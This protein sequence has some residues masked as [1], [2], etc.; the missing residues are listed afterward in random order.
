MED[1]IN[2]FTSLEIFEGR[3]GADLDKYVLKANHNLISFFYNKTDRRYETNI[4]YDES[5]P[6]IFY[7]PIKFVN[8]M[9][10][11]TKSYPGAFGYK[12][13]LFVN[14]YM[15]KYPLNWFLNR[16]GYFTT[17]RMLE[18][19]GFQY[20]EVFIRPNSPFKTFTGFCVNQDNAKDEYSSLRQIQHIQD[21]ELIF[22]SPKKNILEEFRC[23]ICDGEVITYSLYRWDDIFYCSRDIFPECLTL[24]EN[25]AKY[26]YQ[27]DSA[28]VVDI[29]MTEDG[30]FIIEFNSLSSSGLYA[31]DLDVFIDKMSQLTIKEFSDI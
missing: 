12:N 28:Y 21:D 31:C 30:P 23:V 26:S 2:W 5:L 15:S 27:I 1:K 4:A 11:E 8:Q 18:Q 14:Q 10:K 16:E 20:P 24:A 9:M 25:V 19:S 7:G 3:P 6:S 29:A 13:N 22:V 17:L